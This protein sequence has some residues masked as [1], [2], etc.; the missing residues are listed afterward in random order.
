M[1]RPDGPVV[2]IDGPSGAGKS[3]V[4][5]EVARRLGLLYLDTGAL[6][7][8]VGW[9]A[10]REGIDPADPEA[11]A[12]LCRRMEVTV[13]QGTLGETRVRVD[14]EDVTGAIRSQEVAALASAVSALP[15]V[16]ERLLGLQREAGAR[17]GVVLD[18][19]DIGTVVFPDADL[20]IF[21]D[22]SPEV[23]AARRRDELAARGELADPERDYPRIL[24]EVRGRDAADRGRALAPLVRA[25][26]AVLLDTTGMT[27]ETVI[28]RVCDLVRQAAGPA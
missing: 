10:G 8:A 28:A 23:R 24:A 3:T 20:K 19:R 27:L 14:G 6:Y 17:G 11:M 13:F 16:R 2:A 9:K 25:P 12:A 22:A 26:D 21:L 18:G 15:C 7:R 5:R 4:A 1:P